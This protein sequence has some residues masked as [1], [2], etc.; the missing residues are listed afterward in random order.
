MYFSR[1]W[2]SVRRSGF[3]CKN[4]TEISPC[5]VLPHQPHSVASA[6]VPAWI[7]HLVPL[8]PLSLVSPSWLCCPLP[9][10]SRAVQ[11]CLLSRLAVLQAGNET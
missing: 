9:V 6:P 7:P 2:T 4:L 3:K 1:P 8:P 5:T 11:P 10:L